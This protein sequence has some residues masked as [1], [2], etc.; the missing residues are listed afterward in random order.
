MK[1]NAEKAAKPLMF[2]GVDGQSF[3]GIENQVWAKWIAWELEAAR[4]TALI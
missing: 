2:P 3:A 4:Y 1:L